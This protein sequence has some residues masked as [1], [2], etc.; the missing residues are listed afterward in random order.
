MAASAL[1]GLGGVGKAVADDDPAG[2]ESRLND[3]G[4]G[5]RAVGE[6]QRHLGHGRQGAGAGVEQNLADAVAGCGAAGLAEQDRFLAAPCEPCR[7]ALDLGGFAR[8]SRPSSVIK[9]PRGMG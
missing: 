8:P 6:H 1:V 5:L 7:Q 3:L 2:V 9:T 4:D